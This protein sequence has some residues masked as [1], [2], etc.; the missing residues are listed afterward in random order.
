MFHL[1]ENFINNGLA[2][3]F[4]DLPG[5]GKSQIPRDSF[6]IQDYSE[7]I[8]D[9]IK[10]N[11]IHNPIGIGHSFGG[12]VLIKTCSRN[13]KMFNLIILVDSSGIR[14]KK[15]SN[16]IKKTIAIILRPIFLFSFMKSL[17]VKIYKKIGSEDYVTNIKL[18][19]TY[20]NVI[21]EDLTHEL[22]NI[23][24]K[25]LIIWGSNDKDTPIE[26]AKLMNE[27][28]KDSKLEV[29][30]NTGHFP[31]IDQPESFV[32]LVLKFIK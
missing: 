31:F 8:T 21:K 18:Q 28:I 10:K 25:T 17:R 32:N 14:K 5:F 6:L 23:K 27:K 29:I 2:L 16:K 24:N 13:N 15:L 3:Y 9:F 7:I 12:A 19:K 11:K 22:N 1:L 30:V 4:V 20:L 26:N